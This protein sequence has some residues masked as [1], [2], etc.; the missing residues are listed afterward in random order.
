MAGTKTAALAAN[1]PAARMLRT[2]DDRRGTTSPRS[3]MCLVASA[4]AA[5]FAASSGPKPGGTAGKFRVSASPA[6]LRKTARHDG[7]LH[8]GLKTLGVQGPLGPVIIPPPLVWPPLEFGVGRGFI[9]RL[10]SMGPAPLFATSIQPL[11]PEPV[12][13]KAKPACIPATTAARSLLALPLQ[14]GKPKS[15]KK[16]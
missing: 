16:E 14:S 7:G 2:I 15:I 10:Q 1:S 5:A 8:D 13:T 9:R 12:C 4:V 3:I 11:R 6:A